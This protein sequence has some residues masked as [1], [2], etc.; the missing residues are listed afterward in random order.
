[1]FCFLDDSLHTLNI[2][3]PKT[4]AFDVSGVR[5]LATA[6]TKKRFEG[7][8]YSNLLLETSLGL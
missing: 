6:L 5:L 7:I 2:D 1:M 4:E 3:V 8:L